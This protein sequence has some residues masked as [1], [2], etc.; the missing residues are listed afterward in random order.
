[1]IYSPLAA[2][3]WPV[4]TSNSASNKESRRIPPM[5]RSTIY[6]QREGCAS[7]SRERRARRGSAA[8][9]Q[10]AGRS[11]LPLWFDF[12]THQI[13]PGLAFSNQRESVA[14]NERFC[15]Q[16]TRIVI[17]RHHKS[18]SARAHDRQQMMFMHFRHLAIERKE[19]ARFAYRPNDV[20]LFH[21]TLTL[22]L[23]LAHARAC[24]RLVHRYDLVIAVVKRG[25][26]QIVHTRIDN[27]ELFLDGLLDVKDA[28]EQNG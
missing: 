22:T 9:S 13:L 26:N 6:A 5:S 7:S 18:V 15:R 2:R 20:D 4:S 3:A 12:P 14:V 10:T 28:R 25:P 21:A 1:M 11:C 16:R 17:R 19:I 27:C 8:H 24:D 23:T